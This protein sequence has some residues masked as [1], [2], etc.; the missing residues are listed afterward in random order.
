MAKKFVVQGDPKVAVAYLRV[1]TED[2]ELGPE[3]QR[4]Q[5]DTWAQLRGVRVHAW[6]TDRLSGATSVDQRPGMIEALNQLR[7][8]GAGLLVVAR[9]DRLAR[10]VVVAATV[11]R[12]AREAGA[13]VVSVDGVGDGDDPAARLMTTIIDGF[14][15]YERALISA[16]TKA[17]LAV[18]KQKG[19]FVGR[20]PYGYVRAEDGKHLVPSPVGQE[21]V[22]RVKELRAQGLTYRAI[23]QVLWD[24]GRLSKSGGRIMPMQV[25]RLAKRAL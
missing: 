25:Q 22:A 14:A 8:G 12:L 2:Q 9:R 17:A 6:V 7:I 3:A 19:E 18:K 1:S 5:V 15:A 11:D 24:E 4:A 23:S 20:I 10:D 13:R 16:R 21:L